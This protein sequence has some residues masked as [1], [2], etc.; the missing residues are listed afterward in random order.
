M[1]NINCHSDKENQ[2][3]NR[4]RVQEADISKI[5]TSYVLEGERLKVKSIL[6]KEQSYRND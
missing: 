2:H 1:L 6:Y 4:C 5:S 3:P